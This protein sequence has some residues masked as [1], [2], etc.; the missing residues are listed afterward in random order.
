MRARFL[1][2]QLKRLRRTAAGPVLFAPMRL[3]SAARY[4]TPKLT[5]IMMW[6]YRSR[7]ETNLTYGITELNQTYLAHMLSVV[8]GCPYDRV[9]VYLHEPLRRFGVAASRQGV[10]PSEIVPILFG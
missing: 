3:L 4:Y 10:Q 9:M 8:S 7:E 6:L 5:Q 1:R 2:K